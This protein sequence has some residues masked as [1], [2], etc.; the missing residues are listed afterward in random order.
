MQPGILWHS[1]CCPRCADES[2]E[3]EAVPHLGIERIGE[4][5]VVECVGRIVR[6]EAAYKLRE[7]VAS[8]RDARTVVLD[9]SEVGAI[10]VVV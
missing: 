9:L 8:V 1:S 3:E 7:V 2:Y 4:L 5:A 6:S 10:K